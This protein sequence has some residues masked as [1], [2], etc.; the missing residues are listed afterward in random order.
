MVVPLVL[1]VFMVFMVLGVTAL[2]MGTA[3]Y[4]HSLYQDHK[5]QAFYLA[6]SG[7]QTLSAYLIEKSY[8]ESFQNMNQLIE[9]ISDKTSDVAS[10]GDGS[11]VITTERK[12]ENGQQKIDI[13]STGTYGNVSETVAVTLLIEVQSGGGDFNPSSEENALVTLNEDAALA[14]E[15]TGGAFLNGNVMIN[16]TKENSIKFRGGGYRIRNGSLY[17]P[18]TSEPHFVI[19]TDK[20]DNFSNLPPEYDNPNLGTGWI[21]DWAFWRDIEVSPNGVKFASMP[22]YPSAAYPE[23]VFPQF[24]RIGDL[25]VPANLDYT[26][27]WIEGLYYPILQDGYYNSIVPSSSRTITVDMAGGDRIIRVGNLNLTGGNIELANKGENSTLY[28]YVDNSFSMG[29]DRTLN[30]N[31]LPDNVQIYYA[32]TNP[33]TINGAS[34]FSG[35][36]FVKEANITLTAGANMKGNITTLGTYVNVSGGSSANGM[37]L[38]APNALVEMAGSAQILGSVIA[39]RFVRSGGGNAGIVYTPTNFSIPGDFFDSTTNSID[40]QYVVNSWR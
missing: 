24:P 20:G 17:I 38:Y 18:H 36:I 5:M 34:R 39:N 15:L 13:I 12:T 35:N 29:S 26:T 10:F 40:V 32:G 23:P 22:T 37:V 11:I 19:D 21:N 1:I 14:L 6:K 8:H 33:V 4:R 2:S 7:A 25:P 16:A 30:Y 3:D 9:N 31:G 28:L 27:P